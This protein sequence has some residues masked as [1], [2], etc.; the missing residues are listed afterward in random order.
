MNEMAKMIIVLTAICLLSAFALTSLN[1][2]L[3]EQIERQKLVNVQVP[4][5]EAILTGAENVA[6]SFF[7]LEIEGIKW[8]FFPWMENGTCKAVAFETTGLGGYAGPVKVMTGVDLTNDT[9]LGVRVTESSETPGVGSRAADPS[10]LA[11]YD[12][13]SITGTKFALQPAGGDIMGVSGA[14]RTSTAVVDGVAKAVAFVLAHKDEIQ[15]Q[16]VQGR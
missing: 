8:V 1:E 14:T 13:L 3:A 10:Y 9:I 16:A 2:G 7:S 5:A 15:S 11:D 12:G 6:D 4:S